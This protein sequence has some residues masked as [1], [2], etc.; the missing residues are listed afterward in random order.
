[1]KKDFTIEEL[2][3]YI[4]N[5]KRDVEKFL[6]Y[7]SLETITLLFGFPYHKEEVMVYSAVEVLRVLKKMCQ[8]LSLE[9][10]YL[11]YYLET[12]EYRET[13]SLYQIYL[14]EIKKLC[15]KMGWDNEMKIFAGFSYLLAKGYLSFPKSFSFYDSN[16]YSTLGLMGA[17]VIEGRG[18]CRHVSSLLRDLLLESGYISR[19]GNVYTFHLAGAFA[20]EL[21]AAGTA[22]GGAPLR[23]ARGRRTAPVGAPAGPLPKSTEGD[24]CGQREERD[25]DPPSD[26]RARRRAHARARPGGRPRAVGLCPPVRAFRRRAGVGRGR[27][28]APP[29]IRGAPAL[30]QQHQSDRPRLQHLRYRRRAGG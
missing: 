22:P 30:R 16:H 25:P 5:S 6:E 18:C 12:V 1:M 4:E 23:P 29:D 20:P 26:Q 7:V 17:D 8:L 11:S 10:N 13:F 2:Y 27:P 3:Y 28:R 9:R 19:C 21:R 24:P 15:Q 14:E